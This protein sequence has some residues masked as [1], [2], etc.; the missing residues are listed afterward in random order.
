MRDLG[1]ILTYIEGCLP[2]TEEYDHWR[3]ELK[4]LQSSV[5]YASP[6]LIPDRWYQAAEYVNL[7]CN[8]DYDKL[9]E[10]QKKI[11]DVWTDKVQL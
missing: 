7:L 6:E 4:D 9:Q 3:D 11:V 1:K 5:A 2:K 10:W 8:V